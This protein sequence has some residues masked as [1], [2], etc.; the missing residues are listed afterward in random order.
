[1]PALLRTAE[2]R[3]ARTAG[4]GCPHVNVPLLGF[5]VLAGLVDGKAGEILGHLEDVLVALVP[6]RGSFVDHH[7]ALLSEAELHKTGLPDV[8]AQPAGILQFLIAGE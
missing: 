8:G 3:A 7:Y 1:M 6:R 5:F 4:G 2:L